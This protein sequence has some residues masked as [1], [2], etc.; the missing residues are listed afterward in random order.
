VLYFDPTVGEPWFTEEDDG[1]VWVWRDPVPP[2][3]DMLT[4]D[5]AMISRGILLTFV[6]N[7]ELFVIKS[8]YLGDRYVHFRYFPW[9]S[10]IEIYDLLGIFY[11]KIVIAGFDNGYGLVFDYPVYLEPKKYLLVYYDPNENITVTTTVTETVVENV[12]VTQ[13]VTVTATETVTQNVTVAVATTVTE[14]VAAPVVSYRTVTTTVTEIVTVFGW[15]WIVVLVMVLVTAVAIWYLLH[16][17][18]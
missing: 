7:T 17:R 4:G 8:A 16:R 12:T 5:I 15:D 14:A 3:P 18:R 9:Y 13:S 10:T 6:D 11:R 1:V 2:F